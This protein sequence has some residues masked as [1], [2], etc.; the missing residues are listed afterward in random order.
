M[1]PPSRCRTC[2]RL[3]RTKLSISLRPTSCWKESRCRVLAGPMWRQPTRR[4]CPHIQL[5]GSPKHDEG[6]ATRATP[7]CRPHGEPF[8]RRVPAG[9]C[10]C[11]CGVCQRWLFVD[12]AVRC[13]CSIG[14][15]TG[16]GFDCAIRALWFLL[17]MAL[18]GPDREKPHSSP[19]VKDVQ[20]TR[21]L[22]R[23]QQP[24]TC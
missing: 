23:A 3:F 8:A 5:I 6:Q 19:R 20:R 10:Q 18:A 11:P 17:L 16:H 7:A 22:C 9:S 4:S 12:I 13:Q 14:H 15:T 24:S 21:T 1:R 2:P